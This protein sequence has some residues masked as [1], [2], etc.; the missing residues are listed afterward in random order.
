MMSSFLS[1][2]RTETLER[3]EKQKKF[4]N[5]ESSLRFQ[6][7]PFLF[8]AAL[9]SKKGP[10]IIAEIKKMSPSQGVLK[11]AINEKTLAK[12]YAESGAVA[13]SVLTEPLHFNGSL[14][15][16]RSVR[17]A[18]DLP[19]LQKDFIVDTHQILEAKSL[20]ADA[21]LLIV[22]ML[23]PEEIE[24]FMKFAEN[25]GLSVLVE[26]HSLAELEIALS[27][28]AKIIGINNRNLHTL[29]IS[30]DV[31]RELIHHLPETTLAICES[32]LSSSAEILEFEALGFDG[33][34]IGSAF[35]KSEAPHEALRK[36]ISGA[37]A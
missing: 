23:Q 28:G 29:G 24:R 9:R 2:I 25:L 13:L 7:A 21:I 19:L 32:G 5:F 15:D 10:R 4:S 16:L 31:S 26:V 22:A 34:L 3:V 12:Q 11:S 20:G 17:E 33:Y 30:L 8:E 36:I 6:R 14:A 27:F 1:R 18:V 35:M 37:K